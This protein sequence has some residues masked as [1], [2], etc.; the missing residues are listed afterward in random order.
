VW[1]KE[2]HF[3]TADEYYQMMEDGKKYAFNGK[4]CDVLALKRLIDKKP[5]LSNQI[6][7]KISFHC[8]GTPIINA[9]KT[10]L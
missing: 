5:V 6:V 9:N 4:P 1:F 2:Q 10:L 7:L 8:A 3:I